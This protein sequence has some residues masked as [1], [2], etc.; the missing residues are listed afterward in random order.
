MPENRIGRPPAVTDGQSQRVE[1]LALLGV[2]RVLA[3]RP[4]DI[5]LSGVN[6]GNNAAENALYS[7]TIGG[8]MEAALQEIPAIAL[9]QYIGPKIAKAPDLFEAL[10]GQ[11]YDLIVSNP[12][13]VDRED[14]DTRPDEFRHEPEVGLAAGFDGMDVVVRILQ[15]AAQHLAEAGIPPGGDGKYGTAADLNGDGAVDHRGR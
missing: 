8:A 7:G 4:P 1:K 14:M 3:G 15:D 6:R 10:G 11:P 5:V 13:Y 9:S 2:R 12:P